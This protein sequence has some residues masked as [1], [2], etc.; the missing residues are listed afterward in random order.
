LGRHFQQPQQ[1][2]IAALVVIASLIAHTGEDSMA[3]EHRKSGGPTEPNE[4]TLIPV[5]NQANAA[6]IGNL[7]SMWSRLEYMVDRTIWELAAPKTLDRGA[8]ITAQLIG[9]GPRLNALI[10]LA[11]LSGASPTLL[12]KFNQFRGYAVGLGN[13]RHRIIHDPCSKSWKTKRLTENELSDFSPLWQDV[14]VQAI[15]E[16]Q[17]VDR[18]HSAEV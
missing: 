14:C 4:G 3:N 15:I 13:K 17:H 16:A 7:T 5:L 1:E 9:I 10:A 11:T 6:A 8:C 12:K 2:S 18:N